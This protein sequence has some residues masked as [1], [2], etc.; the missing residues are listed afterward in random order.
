MTMIGS[1]RDDR[2]GEVGGFWT[3]DD[4]FCF[5]LLIVGAGSAGCVLASRL[6]ADPAMN[7][8]LVEA[9]TAVTDP[10]V[11]NPRAWPSLQG[12]DIDWRY[13]T[14]QQTHTGG[15]VH[16]CPRGRAIGGSSCINAMAHVRGHPDDFD[17]WMRD[18]CAGWSFADLLPYFKQSENSPFGPSPYHGVDGP[19]ELL[20][21][22]KPHPIT[23]AYVRAG[24]DRGLRRRRT[25]MVRKW[26]ARL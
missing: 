19:I 13:Q 10:A 7:V 3:M 2:H 12:S 14:T 8:G 21:P 26:L 4:E 20:V 23:T 15:R 25:T 5:D 24:V 6:S 1:N 16:A 17:S 11:A 18:G 9:G 22:D